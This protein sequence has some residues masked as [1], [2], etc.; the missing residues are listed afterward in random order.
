MADGELQ[1]NTKIDT[2]GFENGVNNLKKKGKTATDEF[3][4]GVDNNK[5]N[6]LSLGNVAKTVGAYIGVDLFKDAI[7]MGVQFN[8]QVEQ[9]KIA[10]T[11]LTGS[12]EE[13]NKII[14]QIKI[15]ASK[16]PFSVEE[17]T[18]ANQLMLSTGLN[19]DDTRNIVLALGDAIS[20]TGGGNEELSRMIINLQQVKNLGKASAV[21]IKQ[22]AYAGI[23]IYGL[24]ADYMGIT[25]QEASDMEVSWNNL[26]GALLRA[27]QEGGKYYNAMTNQS[28]TLNGQLSNL[29]DTMKS[30]LGE[31]TQ[32]IND[33][34]KDVLPSLISF[35][36][37]IDIGAI[38]N[39]IKTATPFIIALVTALTAYK[40]TMLAIKAPIIAV[41][42]A[43][44]LLN[45]AMSMTPIGLVIAL[46]ATLVATFIYFWNTSEEFRKFWINLW[47]AIVKITTDVVDSIV[48]FFTKTIPQ[49]FNDLV[50][51]L[52][53]IGNSIKQFFSELWQ[54]I[55]NFFMETIPQWIINVGN[56]FNKI[57]YYI[58]YALGM[59]IAYVANFFIELWGFVTTDLPQI[60]SNIIDWFAQLPSNIWNWLM[61]SI[62][63]IINWGSQVYNNSVTFVSNTITAI[64]EF[65]SQLPSKI[66]NW[67]SKVIDNIAKWGSNAL[68]TARNEA[69]DIINAVIDLFSSLPSKML[70]IG[71][72]V[73]EGLWNGIK[74]AKD[75]LIGKV[76]GFVDGFVDGFKDFFGI[77]S[78]SKLMANLIGKFLPQGIA[79]GFD[80]EM[81]KSL[82]KMERTLDLANEGLSVRVSQL[83]NTSGRATA[84]NYY[85]NTYTNNDN[86]QVINFYNAV[87]D[88]I[89]NARRIRLAE[90][91][92]Y[93]R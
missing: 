6:L 79:L 31:A 44:K 36:E 85:G 68:S 30:K 50:N 74:G 35:I 13:A 48:N 91:N 51:E 88:P 22:F 56:F 33:K 3:N 81:P 60:I 76:E 47:D 58:G 71:K 17:L 10:I 25:K 29:S 61:Q 23:D 4:N 83:A 89:E 49:A 18:K 75:W 20:A 63:D 37:N 26:S 93:A 21:D 57:P 92:G 64:I 78:P 28:Y 1:F 15:D 42:T 55:V 53:N 72:N 32:F 12:A 54:G 69:S 5:S 86:T 43:Q 11:T 82:E 41:T 65:F 8:A 2:K 45:L 34:L 14:N 87:D 84:S 52:V 19:A 24:L 7:T 27:S 73:V 90:R 39:G 38:A 59:S 40:L 66:W 62:N 67:L 9:Y 70:D 77:H 80:K 16:T 46:I